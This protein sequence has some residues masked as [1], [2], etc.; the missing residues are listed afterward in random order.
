MNAIKTR[1]VGALRISLF[2]SLFLASGASRDRSIE[3]LQWGPPVHGLQMS[4]LAA[5]SG[6]AD[7]PEFQVALR[8]V[9]GQDVTLNLGLMLANGK[10]QLPQRISLNFTDASGRMRGLRFFD[11]RYPAVAGRLDDYV[12]P[13]RAGSVYTLKFKLDQFVSPDNKEFGLK[14]LPGAYQVVAQF[15]GSGAQTDNLDMPGIR[16]MNFWKGKLQSNAL[17]IER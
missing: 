6:N 3:S 7:A 12:V 14:S 8:N 11:K 15:E 9:G 16:L 1:F 13:L 4:I 2:L 5:D 10:V 17:A